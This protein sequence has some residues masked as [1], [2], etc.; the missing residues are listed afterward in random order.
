MSDPS[1]IHLLE[2]ESGAETVFQHVRGNVELSP[3]YEHQADVQQIV[4]FVDS[5]PGSTIGSAAGNHVFSEIDGTEDT[6]IGEFFRRP[7]RIDTYTWL[8]SDAIGLKQSTRPWYLWANDTTVKNK[9]NNYAF[10]RGDLHV[11]FVI[12]ASPFYYGKTKITY[13]PLPAFTPSTIVFDAATRWFIINSQRPN[14]DI[15]PQNS[16]AGTMILPFIYFKNWVNVQSA[17]DIQNLGQFYYTIYSALQS[18][19]GV[20]GTGVTITTYAW[21]EN[22]RLSG[23]SIGYS[24]QSSEDEYDG[25]VSRPA[26]NVAKVASYFEQIPM[27]GPFATATRIGATAVSAIA[28]MFGFTNVPV[29]KDSV[30]MRS[31]PFPKLAS[32]EISYPVEKLTLDPKNELSID[33]R[34]VGLSEGIDEFQINYIASKESYLTKANWSTANNV[35]DILFYSRVN[36]RL[37]DNDGATEAKIYMTPMA[38]ISNLFDNWRGDIIF[39]FEI[40]ASKYHKGRLRISFDPSGYTALNIGNTALSS[41]VVYTAIVDIGETKS[42]EFKIPY[43]QATQFLYLRSTIDNASEG[44]GVNSNP[45]GT[46]LYDKNYD[47]GF[48]TLR[49]LSALTAPVASSN[50]DILIYVRADKNFE[51]ANPT[52]VDNSHQLSYFVAQ[53][54]EMNDTMETTDV[55]IG[56]NKL[57]AESQYLVHFGENI[58]SVRQLLRRYEYHST[59]Y[60]NIPTNAS[61]GEHIC[62]KK[63]Y[64]YPPSPGYIST[65]TETANT[66]VAAASTYKYNFCQFSFISYVLPAYLCYRGSINWSFNVVCPDN[67][68]N[69]IRCIRDNLNGGSVSYT[70]TSNNTESVNNTARFNTINRQ[71]GGCA[72]A[73]T[74]GNTNTGL[75]V[76]CP[77]YTITKFQTTN[78][79]IANNGSTVDGSAYD[80]FNLELLVKTNASNSAAPIILNNYVG[81]GTD[82]S[83]YF[84]INVPT[85]YYYSSVPTA[86]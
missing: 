33:P 30:P 39:R 69:E 72:Q 26:S 23:A 24:M 13:Q 17:S 60:F 14:L 44:W 21:V 2:N 15:D 48:I 35:D 62:Q 9:L 74:N 1:R 11:K 70:V 31:D 12:S 73:L 85:L 49:V 52:N 50:V 22:I 68:I 18:A 41:N 61:S 28:S 58:R 29:I 66:I 77:N 43:Q 3:I 56:E 78:P 19:N 71:S 10:F 37:Y 47:N 6:D 32:S 20:T 40:V 59:N 46:Y 54:E 83:A 8:E 38:W 81:A 51:V 76:Q 4:T 34:I 80:L 84:F 67:P 57:P 79:A 25:I 36:P 65:G 75:N 86:V 7:V 45:P 55:Y 64:R 5:L 53:S 16:E 82:F 27:I 63:F 42:V